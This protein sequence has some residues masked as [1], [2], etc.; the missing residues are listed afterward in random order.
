MVSE[1]EQR[2]TLRDPE[3]D[4]IYGAVL[5]VR[6]TVA[7]LRDQ[8][9]DLKGHVNDERAEMMVLINRKVDKDDLLTSFG[10][11][12]LRLGPVRWFLGVVAAATVSTTLVQHWIGPDI[13]RAIQR[14]A[15]AL[16]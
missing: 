11:R 16:T 1:N 8:V 13:A 4:E 5:D 3:H 2:P 7:D 14:I 15:H 6:T 9:S 10:E 12:L